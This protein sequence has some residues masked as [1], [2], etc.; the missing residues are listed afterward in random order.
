MRK[1]DINKDMIDFIRD[2]EYDT[3]LFFVGVLLLVGDGD[4]DSAN[5]V[6]FGDGTIVERPFAFEDLYGQYRDDWR[7][8]D[9]AD[10]LFTYLPT[11]LYFACQKRR[12]TKLVNWTT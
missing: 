11:M 2:I 8:A 5:D 7:V 9:E 4:G 1:K 12:F 6:A 10:S 3:L